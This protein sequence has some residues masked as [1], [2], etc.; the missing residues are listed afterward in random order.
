M[1][2]CLVAIVACSFVSGYLLARV[3]EQAKGIEYSKI[4][5]RPRLPW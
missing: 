2:A 1:I 5:R 4:S 3:L